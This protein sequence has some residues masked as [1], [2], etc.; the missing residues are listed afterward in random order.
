MMICKADFEE[1]FP[2]VFAASPPPPAKRSK[3]AS[4]ARGETAE[5]GLAPR[6]VRLDPIWLQLVGLGHRPRA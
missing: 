4:L 2:H 3:D 6:L 5:A 1:L